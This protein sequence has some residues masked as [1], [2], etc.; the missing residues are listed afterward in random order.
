METGKP[1]GIGLAG[2]NSILQ[3]NKQKNTRQGFE[4]LLKKAVDT[5]DSVQLKKACV[6]FEQ[7]FLQMV[8]KQMKAS[9][10]R[11]DFFPSSYAR[12]VFESMMDEKL[13][14]KA[15]E[16]GGLGIAETMF[17]QLEK[18]LENKYESF[19]KDKAVEEGHK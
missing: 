17:R 15:A 8:F 18:Q 14:E 4:D 1:D 3:V 9:V 6:Q 16:S 12:D 2:N 13:M 11:S 19:G 7:L 5:E 10:P